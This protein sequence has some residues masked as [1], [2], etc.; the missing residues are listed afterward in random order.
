LSDA[1]PNP[2]LSGVHERVSLRFA[3][4]SQGPVRLAL[5]DTLGR[6]IRT[7]H[8]AIHDAGTHRISM[9]ITPLSAGVYFYVL[10]TAGV[11][12][13]KKLLVIE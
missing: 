4:P 8:E 3:I 2:A 13:T 10:E 1:F 7:I 5:F 12:L 11:R 6:E 9:D